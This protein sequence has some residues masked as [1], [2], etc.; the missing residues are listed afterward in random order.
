[1]R[2]DQAIR[3]SDLIDTASLYALSIMALKFGPRHSGAGTAL[4]NESQTSSDAFQFLPSR[5]GSLISDHLRARALLIANRRNRRLQH[6]QRF[7]H[8]VYADHQRHQYA[9][10]IGV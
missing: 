6:V 10:D 3:D 4:K 1:M 5:T 7:V 9:N 2:D 8:L